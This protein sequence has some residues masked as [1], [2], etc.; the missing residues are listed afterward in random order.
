MRIPLTR[1]VG[2]ASVGIVLSTKYSLNEYCLGCIYPLIV[3]ETHW[4]V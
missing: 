1:S 4:A 3:Q 2:D